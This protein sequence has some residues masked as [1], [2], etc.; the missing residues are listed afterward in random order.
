[1]RGVRSGILGAIAFLL[2]F[3][4]VSSVSRSQNTI[5]R[6][7][8]RHFGMIR[9]RIDH[10]NGTAGSSNW[11]GYVLLGS[12]FK[13]V[14]G[15]WIVPAADCTGVLGNKFAAFWV[16]LDG[17]TSTT[18]EQIGILTNCA[19]KHPYYYAWYEFYPQ[20]SII[21]TT[22]P[23]QPGDHIS[24]S[25]IYYSYSDKFALTIKDSTTGQYFSTAAAVSGAIRSSAEWIA[26]APCCT[27]TGG[28]LPLTDFGT[29]TFG[30]DSTGVSNTNYALDT[31]STGPIGIFPAVNT[32]EVDKTPTASSPQTSTCSTLSTDG[33]SFTCTWKGLGLSP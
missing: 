29:V 32:I 10:G 21:V 22:V 18:V 24:A 12:S 4:Q 8:P 33:T 17:Y 14:T 11:S 23:I 26:E 31:S 27:S 28:I 13:W 16:G 1:M 5:G 3:A 9:D 20:G 2:A 7:V 30:Q 19:G 15:S 25:V 6:G